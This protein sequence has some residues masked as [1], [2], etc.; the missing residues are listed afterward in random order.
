MYSSKLKQYKNNLIEQ[1][2]SLEQRLT[3]E[4][5]EIFIEVFRKD[6]QWHKEMINLCDILLEVKDENII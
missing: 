3:G 4:I 1:Q 2:N 6:L 5:R